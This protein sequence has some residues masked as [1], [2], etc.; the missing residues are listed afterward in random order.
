[1]HLLF[2][3]LFWRLPSMTQ[4]LQRLC[5]IR[6][7]AGAYLVLLAAS[8]LLLGVLFTPSQQ[9]YTWEIHLCLL[10]LF[11]LSF[12]FAWFN[13]IFCHSPNFSL[14]YTFW[15]SNMK[16][17]F[18]LYMFSFFLEYG[19]WGTYIF[20]DRSLPFFLGFLCMFF[21]WYSLSF[22]WVGS[23]LYLFMTIEKLRLYCWSLLPLI[24]A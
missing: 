12:T 7:D 21:W 17:W 22:P 2:W 13:F 9:V 18:N 20:L 6:T 24:Y 10:F 23:D 16:C 8:V 1:M 15:G 4:P 14:W 3:C 11:T 19:W 5:I